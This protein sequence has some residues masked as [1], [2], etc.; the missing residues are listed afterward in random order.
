MDYSQKGQLANEPSSFFTPGVGNIPAN[1]NTYEEENNLDLTND[2]TPW[3]VDKASSEN[4]RAI[5][6]RAISSSENIAESRAESQ[7]LGEM[8]ESVVPQDM[9]TS[10]ASENIIEKIS[11]DASLIRT[12]GDRINKSAISEVSSV[13]SEFNQT[14]STANFYATVRGDD[15]HPGM[16]RA[17]LKNSYNREVA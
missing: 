3:N 9:V 2:Q 14:G 5:G 6:N 4:I 8:I 10:P 17:N 1:Q 7:P 16:V 13:I 15:E 12:D 11:Y